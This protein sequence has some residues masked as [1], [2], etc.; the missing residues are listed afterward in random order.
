MELAMYITTYCDWRINADD[1][2]LFDQDLSCLETDFSDLRLGNWLASAQLRNGSG[3]ELVRKRTRT[4]T[5]GFMYKPIEITHSKI[6]GLLRQ[7][8][9][10]YLR[11]ANYLQFQVGSDNVRVL[12]RTRN[13]THKR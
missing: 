7:S 13:S 3:M 4:D 9:N 2:A 8:R 5:I 1:I 12:V 11:R 6:H 10:A